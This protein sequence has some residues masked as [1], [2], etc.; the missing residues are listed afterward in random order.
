MQTRQPDFVFPAADSLATQ[1]ASGGAMAWQTQYNEIQ[2]QEAT[3]LLD[4][5]N[6]ADNNSGQALTYGMYLSRNKTISDI[7][8]DMTKQNYNID[9]GASETYLRQGEINE[10][11][12]QNKLDTLFFLQVLFLYLCTVIVLVFLR[13]WALIPTSTMYWILGAFT[14]VLIAILVNRA[15][16]TRRERDKRHWN[17]R[18]FPLEAAGLTTT[19]ACNSS[20]PEV[21]AWDSMVSSGQGMLANMYGSA[22]A[23]MRGE[24][25]TALG[26]AT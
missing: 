3:N 2:K 22:S 14:F 10:W 19:P 20:A 16:Y 5:L 21:N 12:A 23:D 25:E 26:R 7:A 4:A 8:Q 6:H 9:N 24:I 1:Q 17:R 15:W 11:Q 18:Y 13:Q